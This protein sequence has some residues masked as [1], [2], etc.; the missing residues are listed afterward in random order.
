MSGGRRNTRVQGYFVL[1][2]DNESSFKTVEKNGGEG[3]SECNNPESVYLVD[4]LIMFTVTGMSRSM[5]RVT[6]KGILRTA[7]I[8]SS[9]NRILT[10]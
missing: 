6:Q 10:I 7:Y 1:H 3:K 5:L 4:P 8:I 2:R 9:P